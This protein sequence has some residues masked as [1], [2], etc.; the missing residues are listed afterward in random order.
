MTTVSDDDETYP[1]QP[2]RQIVDVGSCWIETNEEFSDSMYALLQ[3]MVDATEN[4]YIRQRIAD[5]DDAVVV[6]TQPPLGIKS[7]LK[8]AEKNE[9]PRC[10]LYG[11]AFDLTLISEHVNPESSQRVPC[12]PFLLTSTDT[13]FTLCVQELSTMKKYMNTKVVA[14]DEQV[15][16]ILFFDDRQK[17]DTSVQRFIYIPVVVDRL[18]YNDTET[19]E[20]SPSTA[21]STGPSMVHAIDSCIQRRCCL[22]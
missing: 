10:C 18:K 14:D 20:L 3:D 11:Y 6:V 8:A 4:G 5:A 17:D 16:F 12:R 19:L 9:P 13:A 1:L 7:V 21:I 15:V 2:D 22:Q